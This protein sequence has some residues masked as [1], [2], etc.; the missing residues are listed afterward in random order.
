MTIVAI[1]DQ[2]IEKAHSSIK[3]SLNRIAKKQFKD[4]RDLQGQFIADILKR[5]NGSTDL[6][7]VVK[8]TDLVIE[9]V[10]ENI[11]IKHEI[12]RSIDK[13]GNLLLSNSINKSDKK[14]FFDKKL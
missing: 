3:I 9:A 10:I 7:G 14:Y 11:K 4:D 5:L 6:M 12:F 13:V 8:Q 2:L 1:N